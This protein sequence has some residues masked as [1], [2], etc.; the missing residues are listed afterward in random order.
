MEWSDIYL[1]FQF[2]ECTSDLKTAILN[3]FG[4]Y[5]I[6]LHPCSSHLSYQVILKDLGLGSKSHTYSS[7]FLYFLK[8]IFFQGHL[9]GS[10][11]WASDS[12]FRLRSWSH[13]LW[14]QVLPSGIS[15]LGILSLPLSLP[16]PHSCALSK[17]TNIKKST[18]SNYLILLL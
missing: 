5:S 13:G 15:L 16:L 12:W 18:S 14:V 17:L 8:K 7:I 10:V 4:Y 1:S 2:T 6:Q 9:G 11:S 3:N